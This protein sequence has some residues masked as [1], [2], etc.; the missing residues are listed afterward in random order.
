MIPGVVAQQGASA[1]S[2]GGAETPFWLPDGAIAHLDF[3][4]GN[5][6]A[7]E[8]ERTHTDI[9][10]GNF[11]PADIDA[12]GLFMQLGA[13]MHGPTAIGALFTD[14]VNFLQAGCTIAVDLDAESGG[15]LTFPEGTII[16]YFDDPDPDAANHFLEVK[17]STSPRSV[18]IGDDE[19]LF[20]GGSGSSIFTSTGVQAAAFTLNALVSGPAYRYAVSV[21]GGA[22]ANSDQS[23]DASHISVASIRLFAVQEWDYG[24]EDCYVR[25]LT[26]F[27]PVSDLA[28]LATYSEPYEIP[29]G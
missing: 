13:N 17:P 15:S 1:E 9:L 21:N 19:T 22:A 16:Y 4:N 7:G 6:W 2:G 27:P 12:N 23:Y 8:A 26:L 11:D 18:T 14:L 10:G 28:E 3:V 24:L 29:T 20:V 5:Y 25:R